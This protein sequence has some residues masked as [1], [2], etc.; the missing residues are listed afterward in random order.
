MDRFPSRARKETLP[1]PDNLVKEVL[2]TGDLHIQEERR[3]FYVGMTRAKELLYFTASKFYAEGKREKKL[4]PFIAEAL[5]EIISQQVE[6]Y[7]PTQLTLLEATKDYNATEKVIH[8][9][10]VKP[11]QI[12]SISFSQLQAFDLCPL[13]YKAR[14][15][16]NIPI[17]NSAP[18]SFGSSI[19]DTLHELHEAST[20]KIALEQNEFLKLLRKNWRSEGYMSK[21]YEKEMFAHG[22]TILKNYYAKYYDPT[23]SP[24]TLEQP[25]SF[26]INKND[27]PKSKPVKISG[28]IDRIDRRADGGIEIIDYKTGKPKSLNKR[29]YQLQLG[30]YALAATQVKNEFL[31]KKPEEI[32]V[33]LLYLETGE[34]LTREITQDDLIYTTTEIQKKIQEIESSNFACSKN[35]LCQNCEYKMLCN[36]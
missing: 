16:L 7:S 13:H 32:T 3:L 8:S 20:K 14:Y 23:H 21:A 28:F 11:L 4:S 24:L 2:P 27:D 17:P 12:Q 1:I 18:I 29:S 9:D 31:G 5:P 30:L 36:S 10:P 25:F 19:H 22:S 15:I 34:K 6:K 26:F 35:M 33:S